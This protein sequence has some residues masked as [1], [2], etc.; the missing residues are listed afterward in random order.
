MADIVHV[1][2]NQIVARLEQAGVPIPRREEPELTLRGRHKERVISARMSPDESLILSG[3]EDNLVMLS[4]HLKRE[5][6][7]FVGHSYPVSA[8]AFRDE[9]SAASLGRDGTLIVWD[10]KKATQVWS[11]RIISKDEED[12]GGA[13]CLAHDGQ[14]AAFALSNRVEIYDLRNRNTALVLNRF[15]NISCMS[16]GGTNQ[17][18]VVGCH[19]EGIYVV[20]L[21]RNVDRKIETGEGVYSIDAS[22]SGDLWIAAGTYSGKVSVFRNFDPIL[23]EDVLPSCVLAV[24]VNADC[25]Q[26]VAGGVGRLAWW[27]ESRQEVDGMPRNGGTHC[28]CI[29]ATGR[30]GVAG[31]DDGTIEVIDFGER[32]TTYVS[33]SKQPITAVG[34]DP[35]SQE[36][37]LGSSGRRIEGWNLRK[38]GLRRF[39]HG[40][41]GVTCLA[42]DPD[43][44]LFVSGS[45]GRR[46]SIWDSLRGISV[47]SI[48]WNLDWITDV[49]IC[50]RRRYLCV[51]SLDGTVKVIDPETGVLTAEYEHEGASSVTAW[52]DGHTVFSGG[53][54]SIKAFDLLRKRAQTIVNSEGTVNALAIEPAHNLMVS[55]NSNQDIRFGTLQGDRTASYRSHSSIASIL[56]LHGGSRVVAGGSNGELY[57]IDESDQE[58]RVADAHGSGKVRLASVG[59]GGHFVSA[60]M[61]GVVKWW[62]ADARDPLLWLLVAGDDFIVC[63]RNGGYWSNNPDAFVEFYDRAE[64]SPL[65]GSD[66]VSYKMKRHDKDNITA[67]LLE[68]VGSS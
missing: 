32:R 24:A 13:C 27:S 4:N 56:L 3:G 53:N 12:P 18:L 54:G 29:S 64:E 36:V 62:D 19:D 15:R 63:S 41:G 20:D 22:S 21:L 5:V 57:I 60:G 52:I 25:G 31:V 40:A 33:A 44:G 8:V 42:I 6:R 59:S 7:T 66:Y 16:F 2:P 11:Q 49:H 38:G 37:L 46:V 67:Q 34:Y 28:V 47:R 14:M 9:Y 65:R 30:Y 51:A 58:A 1:E 61:D 43:E 17:T 39:E 10:L 35:R 48:A 45:T 68:I 55:G 50:A 26:V 23:S